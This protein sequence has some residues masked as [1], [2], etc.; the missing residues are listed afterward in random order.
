MLALWLIFGFWAGWRAAGKLF[1]LFM[2]AFLLLLSVRSGS[3]L[4]QG[5]GRME[6]DGLLAVTTLPEA[7]LLSSDVQ[8]ISSIRFGDP[9]EAP[10]QV[11]TGGEAPDPVVGWLLREMRNLTWVTAPDLAA[12]RTPE[13][14]AAGGS[15]DAPLVVGP[16]DMTADRGLGGMIGA[17]YALTMRWEPSLLP[18]LPPAAEAG[19]EGLPA[20]EL[21]R[22]RSEQAWSQATRPRLEWLLYRTIK[23]EPGV[24]SVTLWAMP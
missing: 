2:A 4:A 21:A 8:R 12:G 1:G 16:G 18:S 11:V 24:E 14:I 6:P 19:G 9:T 20:E 13:E 22:L 23:S 5:A 7:R 15:T 3:L 17:R 10:V